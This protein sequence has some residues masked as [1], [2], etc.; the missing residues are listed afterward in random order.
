MLS[1]KF[2]SSS[3]IISAVLLYVTYAALLTLNLLRTKICRYKG[4]FLYPKRIVKY[5]SALESMVDLDDFD[6]IATINKK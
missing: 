1:F 3:L 2:I 4:Y 5:F 6:S